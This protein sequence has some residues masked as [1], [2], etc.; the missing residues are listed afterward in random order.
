[1][2][3]YDYIGR[4]V[5]Q[6]ES[7]LQGSLALAQS[8]NDWGLSCGSYQLTLRWGNCINF[9]KKY[10]P[11]EAKSLFF[12]TKKK[13][14]ASKS[15]PGEAY[16]SSPNDVKLCWQKCYNS[17]GEQ[18]FFAYEHEYMEENFYKPIK[19]QMMPY[20]N[21]NEECRA[22]QECFWSWAIH[23]GVGG[24]MNEFRQVTQK[25]DM[26]TITKDLLFDAIYDQR[27]S[28]FPYPRYQKGHLGSER[29]VLRPLLNTPGIGNTERNEVEMKK[30]NP[31]TCIMYDSTCYKGTAKLKQ[32][33][34]VLWH[35]TG[36]NNPEIRAYV[37]PS[38]ADPKYHE[39]M[40]IIG[41]N[42]GQSD[43]NHIYREAGVNAWIGKLSDGSIGTVQAL[44]WD[45]RP[46]GCGSGPNGSCNDGWIQFEICEDSLNNNDYFREVY[47]EAVR[48]TAYLC[49]MYNINPK[50]TVIHNGVKVPTILCHSQSHTLGLGS[51]HADVMHWFSRYGK[52]MDNVRE[53]VAQLLNNGEEEEEMTQEQFNQMMNNYLLMLAKEAP[54]D[55]SKSDREFCESLGLITGDAKGNKMYR[56]FVTREELAAVV[57]RYNEKTKE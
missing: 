23:R 22:L 10:F 8:G 51:N 57:H 45:Y 19:T 32:I 14:F 3:D 21:L 30:F 50:G 40:G 20:M 52:T 41:Q 25:C 46:W 2:I 38:L 24:A 47:D 42:L 15:W 56:K 13:D 12:N 9:L 16:C 34:G 53:D 1:M 55:W 7:G 39:L 5:K 4:Y 11:K 29:E 33:K 48:L 37:Q 49:K 17:V 31:I 18:R 44:P 54:S 26:K 28:T 35:S 36:C 6:F 27:Y 43:W